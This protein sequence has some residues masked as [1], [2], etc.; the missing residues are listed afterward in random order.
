MFMA[1][2]KFHEIVQEFRSV[3][4]GRS[5]VVDSLLPPLLFVVLSAL[6]GL[7]AAQWG[8]LALAL[9]FTSVRLVRRQS[10]QYA[11]GGLFGSVLAVSIARLL[12]RAEG[13]F[14]PGIISGMGTILLAVVSL[15]VRRPMVAWTS[16]IARRWPQDW[17]WHPRVRP[18]Y[19]EVTL[20]W[21]GYY[22]SRSALQ[23]A[24]FR[25]GSPGWLAVIRLI[26]GWPG[27]IVLLAL[28]Y[29]YG[30]WRLQQLKG[31]SIAEFEQ[32]AKPP[33]SG[34]TRGF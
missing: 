15:L 6:L 30:T 5:N 26:T 16:Y 31:P 34:Q 20:M 18:A 3:V 27:T 21:I 28:S 13:Y 4:L 9:L 12:G 29:L 22:L 25:G 23:W 7:E 17:Y 10:L 32:G 33:W 11:L 8:A 19:D 1:T 14:L 2:D 24:A